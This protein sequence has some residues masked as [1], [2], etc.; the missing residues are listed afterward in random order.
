MTFMSERP[1]V[2]VKK[3]KVVTYKVAW[4]D[5]GKLVGGPEDGK[6]TGAYI[7][8]PPQPYYQGVAG[9]ILMPPQTNFV[10]ELI[11]TVEEPA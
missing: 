8:Q 7:T 10:P 11:V 3:T 1:F 2:E 9:Q 6:V 5:L 4:K